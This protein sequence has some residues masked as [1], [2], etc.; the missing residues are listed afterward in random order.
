MNYP[1]QKP[2]D[3]QKENK[4]EANI[5][6]TQLD[7]S[8]E[9]AGVSKVAMG[10]KANT[11]YE[12]NDVYNTEWIDRL[13]GKK[14][15]GDCGCEGGCEHKEDVAATPQDL[16]EAYAKLFEGLAGIARAK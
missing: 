16:N 7:G 10:Q 4:G 3:E 14:A 15:Q 11:A 2:E 9:G 5:D 13:R 1:K 12:E 8:P 6:I